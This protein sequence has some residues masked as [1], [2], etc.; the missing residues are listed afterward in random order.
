MDTTT[1]ATTNA[2]TAPARRTLAEFNATAT[3]R[4]WDWSGTYRLRPVVA[5]GKAGRKGSGRDLHMLTTERVVMVLPTAG[6]GANYKLGAIFAVHA[7]CGT[8]S[9]GQHTAHVVEGAD[10]NAVTCER[11]IRRYRWEAR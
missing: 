3:A 6:R 7:A 9:N 1:N 5:V 8:R 4:E 11:C 10:T 2:A